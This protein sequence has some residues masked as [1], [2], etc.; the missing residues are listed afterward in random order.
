MN[1]QKHWQAA[2]ATV[3]EEYLRLPESVRVSLRE[4]G[5]AIRTAKEGLHRLAEET[6]SAAIC[7]S[8]GGECC[9]RGKYHFTVA[10]LLVHRSTGAELFKP[11]FGRDFCPYLGDAGCLMRPAL[12]P[13]NCITF[14]CERVEGLWEPSRID[15]FYRRERELRH[16]Y[17]ELEALLGTRVMQGLLMV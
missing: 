15:E 12:R 7:A 17:E 13:F 8:C 3:T 1:D 16:L 9:L 14:N 10:D 5:V 6:G 4:K 11:R 2:V